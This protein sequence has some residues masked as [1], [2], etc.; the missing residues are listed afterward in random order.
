[1]KIFSFLVVFSDELLACPVFF[2]LSMSYFSPFVLSFSDER[3]M[4]VARGVAWFAHLL[5]CLH[6]CWLASAVIRKGERRKKKEGK[7]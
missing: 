4:M 1:L 6:A 7:R 2:I 5:P 3:Y